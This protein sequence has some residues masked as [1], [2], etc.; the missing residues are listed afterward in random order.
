MNKKAIGSQYEE[1]AAAYM[2]EQGFE[3]ICR[4]YKN[5]IGE[6]DIIAK[7]GEYLVFCE[8]K[9]RKAGD[10][11]YAISPKKQKQI[12]RVAASFMTLKGWPLDT[13]CRFDCAL[14]DGESIIYIKNAWQI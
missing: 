12:G 5:R 6:I 8:V 7:D 9:Y 4:N 3:I 1:A 10:A 13:Y 2:K 14:S 11:I